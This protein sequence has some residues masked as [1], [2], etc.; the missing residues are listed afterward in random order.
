VPAPR[1]THL[2][3]SESAYAYAADSKMGH[4]PSP[5]S[6][7]VE[8]KEYNN[9]FKNAKVQK[10]I[11]ARDELG[12]LLGRPLRYGARPEEVKIRTDKIKEYEK[13]LEKYKG[14][15]GNYD[16]AKVHYEQFNSKLK[17]GRSVR[18]NNASNR[19]KG[20]RA[21]KTRRFRK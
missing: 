16:Q 7:P 4:S 21:N 6:T 13:I 9:L 10:A 20:S 11:R 5:S 1:Q 8:F 18:R 17:G 19:R 2:S 12:N 15:L 14:L 3:S